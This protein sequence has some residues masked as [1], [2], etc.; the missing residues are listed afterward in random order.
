M[1]TVQDFFEIYK[2][3]AWNKDTESMIGLYDDDVMIFDMWTHGYQNGLAEWSSIIKDWLGSLREEK[4]NVIF[5]MIEIRE[6]DNVGFGRAL[7]TYQAMSI[8]NTIV[9][10]MRNRI[11]LGFVKQ[12][13][14]WKVVHQHTSAPIN[15][16]LNAILNF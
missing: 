1:R 6:G 4:V 14:V 8:D 13:D 12:K 2:Q 5:E 3:S 16:D 11:T 7:I 15:A 9:R 10:S